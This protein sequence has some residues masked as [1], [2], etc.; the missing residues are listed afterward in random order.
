[1]LATF[2]P[3]RGLFYSLSVF[4]SKFVLIIGGSGLDFQGQL[5]YPVHF[6]PKK[7][8]E[9]LLVYDWCL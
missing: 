6:P 3:K 7:E 8:K 4:L 5:L 2:S 1:M 9:G